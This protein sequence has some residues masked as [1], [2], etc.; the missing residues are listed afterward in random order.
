MIAASLRESCN[1]T[2]KKK[3]TFRSYKNFDEA[4]LNNDLSRVPFQ[5]AHTFVDVD[6]IYWAHELLL[7]E[8]IE[9]HAPTKEKHLNQTRHHT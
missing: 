7:R 5:V 3:V 1:K 2:E 8:V 6:D 9:E 4:Q